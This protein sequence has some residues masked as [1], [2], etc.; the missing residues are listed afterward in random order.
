MRYLSPTIEFFSNTTLLSLALPE[1]NPTSLH[2]FCEFVQTLNH[3]LEKGLRSPSASFAISPTLHHA[4]LDL[5]LTLCD[6]I[7]KRFILT[8]QLP[9]DPYQINEDS[10]RIFQIYATDFTTKIGLKIDALKLLEDLL[11]H[12]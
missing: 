11:N 10:F 2:E 3:I 12:L 4:A 5:G 6:R 8:A 1:P 9:C 7:L